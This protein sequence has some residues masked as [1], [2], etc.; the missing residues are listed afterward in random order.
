MKAK[1]IPKTRVEVHEKPWGRELWYAVAPGYLGKIIEID[2]GHR[3]SLQFH[4]VKHET[5]YTLKGRF[6]LQ[7][8]TEKRVMNQGSVAVI[9]PGTVH[10]FEARYGKVVLLEVS[11]PEAED[12]VRLADDYGRQVTDR[13]KK[14]R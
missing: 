4:K 7:L 13:R 5:V 3:L 11:T 2:K 12:V 10:R 6:F 8:G 9:P 1:A 14:P